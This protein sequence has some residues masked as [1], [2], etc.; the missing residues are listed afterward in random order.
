LNYTSH[1][2]VETNGKQNKQNKDQKTF[3]GAAQACSKDE[4]SSAQ[5]RYY[6]SL[7]DLSISHF[8][9][10]THTLRR[11]DA[12]GPTDRAPNDV[13]VWQRVPLV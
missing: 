4:R 9:L 1:K 2:G 3:Q 13:D 12:R 7:I 10:T 5:G 6:S 11:L 8:E